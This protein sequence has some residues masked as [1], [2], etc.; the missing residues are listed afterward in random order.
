MQEQ[1]QEQEQEQVCRAG[2]GRTGEDRARQDTVGEGRTGQ[3][4]A[5]Q[6]T[7]GQGRAGQG[8]GRAGQS[9]KIFLTD[10]QRMHYKWQGFAT[11]CSL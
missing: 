11:Q 7:V 4:R 10:C 5:G 8:K 2:Q 1:E 3:G 6:D 9:K